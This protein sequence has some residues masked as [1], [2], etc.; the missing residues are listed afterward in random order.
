MD[1]GA[2]ICDQFAKFFVILE[3]AFTRCDCLCR[4]HELICRKHFFAVRVINLWNS[5]PDEL[6]STN[7]LSRFKTY[8]KQVNLNNF[9]T[10]KA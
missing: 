1:V 3:R 10:G 4:I 5:L 7:Q 6:V 2:G 8:I 9:L